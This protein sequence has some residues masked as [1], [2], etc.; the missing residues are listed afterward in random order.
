[1]MDIITKTMIIMTTEMKLDPYL[2][3]CFVHVGSDADVVFPSS[4]VCFTGGSVGASV[5]GSVAG[6]AGGSVLAVATI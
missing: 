6:G 4:V 2:F 3:L 1:M 5:G